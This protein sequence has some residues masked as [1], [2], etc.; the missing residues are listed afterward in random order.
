MTDIELE[1]SVSEL[2]YG[3]NSKFED[4]FKMIKNVLD[5]LYEMQQT[6][7][8]PDAIKTLIELIDCWRKISEIMDQKDSAS[9]LKKIKEMAGAI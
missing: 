8:D 6:N 2:F 5:C 4:K 3:D 1:K 7:S 9:Y